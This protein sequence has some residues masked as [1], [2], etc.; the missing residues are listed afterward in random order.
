MGR[1]GHLLKSR[2]GVPVHRDLP[3]GEKGVMPIFH[4][5]QEVPCNPCAFIC[6]EGAIRTEVDTITRRPYLV[7]GIRCKGCMACVAICLGLAVTLVDYRK[8]PN[9]PTVTLP[10]EIWR[11]RVEKGQRVPVTDLEGLI[12][13][14]FFPDDGSASPLLA[15][16][17]FAQKALENGVKFQFNERITTLLVKKGRVVGVRTDK[18][19]YRAP[20][21]GRRP[22]FYPRWPLVWWT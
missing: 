18:A 11:E 9:H 1:E 13:G 2:P 4:C 3:A 8:D 6:P 12:G 20:I 17:A 19:K 10:H 14:T 15:I 5:Q 7:E 16:N 22:Y 21:P